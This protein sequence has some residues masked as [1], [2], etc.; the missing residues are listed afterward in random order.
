MREDQ[1]ISNRNMFIYM[2]HEYKGHEKKPVQ[3]TEK[4]EIHGATPREG[5]AHPEATPASSHK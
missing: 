4:E 2:E 3:G 5:S 1:F